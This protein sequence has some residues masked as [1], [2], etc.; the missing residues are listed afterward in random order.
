MTA[1]TILTTEIRQLDGLYSLNDLHKAAGGKDK[2]RPTFF[3]RNEQTQ[4]LIKE[5]R[6][7][8][9]HIIPTKTVTGRGKQ[10]GTYVC[11]ELVYAYAMWISA[12]FH[13]QVIRAFDAQ[14]STIDRAEYLAEIKR[15]FEQQYQNLRKLYNYPSKLLAQPYFTSTDGVT[16]LDLSMLANTRKFI[17]PLFGLLNE[18]RADGHDVTAPL[19]EAEAMREHLIKANE[20][21]SQIWEIALKTQHAPAKT[22]LRK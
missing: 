19:A 15:E 7:A 20:A 17:S 3:L 16:R 12:K 2:H 13:L 6:C 21:F 8:D 10:Q 11:R 9:S 18:L 4:E 1:L 22:A 5:L 14:H